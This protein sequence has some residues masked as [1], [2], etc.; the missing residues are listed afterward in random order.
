MSAGSFTRRWLILLALLA[1]LIAAA[2][3][4]TL[5]IAHAPGCGGMGEACGAA[6][7]AFDSYGR[8][9]LLAII[10]LLLVT[11]LS[12]RALAVGVFAWALP[13]GLLMLAGSVPLLL[14]VPDLQSPT[15]LAEIAALPALTPFLFLIVHFIALSASPEDSEAGS[16]GAAWRTVLGFVAVATVFVTAPAWLVG[17]AS[18]PYV[19]GLA[20]P[21]AARVAQAHAALHIDHELAQITLACL[22]AFIVA[23]GGLVLCGPGALS[24]AR[25]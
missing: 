21:I 20:A 3:Y 13:F 5:G 1:G 12:A 14:A 16:A 19:G 8:W 17:F 18:L 23:A 22:V 24:R 7:Q 11:S 25:A 2:P 15:F 10:V 9:L 6:A 4:I